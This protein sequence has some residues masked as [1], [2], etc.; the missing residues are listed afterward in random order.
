MVWVRDFH[1]GKLL[2]EPMLASS[3]MKWLYPAPKPGTSP[4]N[5]STQKFI[6]Q[7][8][9]TQ[10]SSSKQFHRERKQGKNSHRARSEDAIRCFKRAT[11]HFNPLR[12]SW[13]RASI[14]HLLTKKVTSR[15]IGLWQKCMLSRRAIA[16]FIKRYGLDTDL[17][18]EPIEHFSS[19]NDF[20]IRKLKPQ[21][22]PIDPSTLIAP[23]DGRYFFF[24]DITPLGSWWLKGF[25]YRLQD[26]L[27]DV[28]PARLIGGS[29]ISI[30]LCPLDYHRFHCPMDARIDNIQSV[31][32]PLFSVSPLATHATSNRLLMNA[33]K[34]LTMRSNAFS[35]PLY[36]VA[37]GATAV[38]SIQITAD[39]GKELKRG[40]EIG[41]FEFG[42][43]SLVLILPKQ[44]ANK[45]VDTP[46]QDALKWSEQLIR[47]LE[48]SQACEL[49]IKMGT[50]LAHIDLGDLQTALLNKR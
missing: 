45:I 47:E 24:R 31:E 46:T 16:P 25:E 8:R 14:L 44:Y 17:F 36:L 20:F 27:P 4:F 5:A 41:Y 12:G 22:R 33:R 29:L 18:A 9:P 48:R 43:S 32:G 35:T 39:K 40:D 28:D 21:A 3:L 30:R 13:L 34:I 42:G 26:L 11:H 50:A 37:I 19:F 10:A 23:A 49:F 6:T 38:G 15:C 7:K 1:S 2:K